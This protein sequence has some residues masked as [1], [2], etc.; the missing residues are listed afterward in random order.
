MKVDYE[1][2]VQVLPHALVLLDMN[3]VIRYCNPA[4]IALTGYSREELIGSKFGL[5]SVGGDDEIKAGYDF[6]QV[7]S[8]GKL[9]REGWKLRKDSA[10]IWVSTILTPMYEGEELSGYFCVMYDLTERKMTELKLRRSEERYRL[11]VDRVKDYSI[12]MLDTEGNILTW[13]EGAT[14]LTGY[15]PSEIIGKH[16]SLFYIPE[17][18]ESKK[19]ERE[20]R[21]AM[22]TGKYEEEGWR[23]KKN[24]TLFWAN[25][26]LT[27]L[28]NG[29]N[30]LIGFS[31][32]TRDLS[33]KREIDEK[34]KASEER[35]RAIV[36]QVKDYGIFM[37]DEEGRIISWN[38]GAKR[39]KG[40]AEEDI[41]GKY[42]SIFYP[43]EDILNGKPAMELKVAKATG[44][45]EEEGWRL[46]KD[47]S[48][49]W[50]NVI[51]TAV[52]NRQGGHIGFSKVTR[53]LTERKESEK[54]LK[55][56]NEKYKRLAEELK[57]LNEE[58]VFTNQ[59]LQQFTSIASH[60]LQE[61]ARTVKSFLKL[62]EM[63][64]QEKK[65]DDVESYIGKSIAATDRMRELIKSLLNYAQLSRYDI[66]EERVNV[67]ELFNGVIQN[68]KE[69]IESSGAEVTF[70]TS[71]DSVMGDKIQLGQLLQNLIN[72]AIKFTSTKLPKV[73]IK[74]IME[75]GSPLFSVSDNGI[76]IAPDHKHQV[77]EIFR[78]L[79]TSNKYPGT[80]IGLAI[81]MKI[82]DR[83]R[84]KIW[85]ESTLGEGTSF[86]FTLHDAVK[87]GM[88]T[89]PV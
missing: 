14:K 58:L 13:N 52:Y 42:F 74:C 77:F 33:E 27:A 48:R 1:H 88:K 47:G 8:K 70:E 12:F 63:R 11:L 76:G 83:H 61:P 29:E 15:R 49:F 67:T 23:V 80:G 68:L 25:I 28:F 3:S 6:D 82:V 79:N 35:Y 10:H 22:E 2:L 34:I 30:K 45:Y 84:G 87:T 69:L 60:D 36:E 9:S 71:I 40:Y 5:L 89:I 51:I 65:Y 66:I 39:I 64:L 18:L 44:K 32:V 72:N 57:V 54:A 26:V 50:A 56:S 21:I 53:D 4:A 38:E 7:V 19:P 59:E 20:L 31:K 16:F 62:I 81:C 46:R 24:G 41:I 37:M 86:F 73:K 75:N 85:L 43:E 78:R 17:D 55:A